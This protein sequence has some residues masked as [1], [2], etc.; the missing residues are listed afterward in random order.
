MAI[1]FDGNESFN[2]SS[3][4]EPSEVT[5]C[6]WIRFWQ[7]PTSGN[8]MRIFGTGNYW[9]ARVKDDHKIYNELFQNGNLTANTVLQNQVYYHIALTA[10]KSADEGN[11]YIDGNLD[12]N[13]DGYHDGSSGNTNLG[14]GARYNNTDPINARLDDF[15]IY[16]RVLLPAEIQTIYFSRGHDEIVYGLQNRWLMNEAAHGTNATSII[17]CAGGLT[18]TV[19]GTPAYRESQLSLKKKTRR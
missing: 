13:S 10:N 16:N 17:D 3:F 9:E 15:R 8:T 2:I 6:F 1:Y 5:V 18:S 12:Y 19:V 11:T 7:L 4:S 14:I